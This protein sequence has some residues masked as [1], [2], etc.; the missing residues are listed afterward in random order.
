MGEE[1]KP[2]VVICGKTAVGKTTLA[3]ELEKR[4]MKR[5]ITYTTRPKRPGETDGVDY[6]FVDQDTFDNMRR[7]GFFAETADYNASFGYCS[8]GSAKD[9]YDGGDAFIILNP[10]GIK[11]I[12]D[13]KIDAVVIFLNAPD[14][15]LVGRLR[16][17]G[18]DEREIVRRMESDANDFADIMDFCDVRIDV[19]N[20][21][22][23]DV[24]SEFVKG[25]MNVK[26]EEKM[27]KKERE[28]ENMMSQNVMLRI[29]DTQAFMRLFLDDP[30]TRYPVVVS[31]KTG[32]PN[33]V[34]FTE[35]MT[36]ARNRDELEEVINGRNIVNHNPM[37]F[38]RYRT[39]TN[40]DLASGGRV[41][42]CVEDLISANV[43]SKDE[44]DRWGHK[45]DAI[46]V[47]M[48]AAKKLYELMI[49]ERTHV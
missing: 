26:K 17:R 19:T 48:D 27:E 8:Y 44:I 5:V 41:E 21:T 28:N 38:G 24:L 49:P 9:D 11:Q 3:M 32:R 14:D 20:D 34:G 10:Y 6:H 16:K 7:R 2:I 42:A 33:R 29:T 13:N 22:D 40:I 37:R 30:D 45:S 35:W 15:V 25:R 46:P 43:L 36:I 4:G 1:H 39:Q 12:I 23:I 18:D 31:T 47:G